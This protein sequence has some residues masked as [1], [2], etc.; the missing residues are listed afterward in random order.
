M[1]S[2][3]L[4]ISFFSAVVGGVIVATVNHLFFLRREKENKKRETLLRYLLEAYDDLSVV[5]NLDPK[6]EVLQIERAIDSLQLIADDRLIEL[7]R[8]YRD[9]M[10]SLGQTNTD[11]LMVYM[12]N[13]IRKELGLS[14]IA[15]APF[16]LRL[17]MSEETQQ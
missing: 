8:R 4:L 11:D 15:E 5:S 3:G 6:D 10:V 2:A 7:T 13:L 17:K 16:Y 1:S 9:E 14:P 12:R